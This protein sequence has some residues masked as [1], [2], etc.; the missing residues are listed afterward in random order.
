MRKAAS[1]IAGEAACTVQGVQQVGNLPTHCSDP[2]KAHCQESF[3]GVAS[4][5]LRAASQTGTG[6]NLTWSGN[7]IAQGNV[8]VASTGAYLF[9]TR[10]FINATSG[11]GIFQLSNTGGTGF[12][13]L[14]F[15]GTTTSFPALARSTTG[16]KVRLADD[17]AD[18]GFTS[19]NLIT[20]TT[21]VGFNGNSAVGKSAA[22]T[23][24]NSSPDRSYDA[25]STTVNELA[26]VCAALIADLQSVGLL[27]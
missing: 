3:A 6:G 21:G 24:T 8:T 4:D 9:S 25:T 16:L 19:A 27:G 11:D 10:G 7:I 15:G 2:V 13:R 22:Y 23:V 18:A 17:S 5:F 14:Q 20:S 1:L 26:Q 12:S